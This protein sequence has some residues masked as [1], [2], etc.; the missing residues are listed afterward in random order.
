MDGLQIWAHSYCRS[1]L[2]FYDELSK[3]LDVPLRICL[4]KVDQGVRQGLGWSEHEFDHLD[5]IEIGDDEERAAEELKKYQ[6]WHQLFGVY[7]IFPAIQKTMLL[8]K[9]LG[10]KIGVCSE[11]PLNMYAPG[12]KSLA[13]DIYLDHIL[14][15]RVSRYVSASS[16]ICNFSG[17]STAAL[18]RL[19]WKSGQIIPAG[20]YSP[21]LDGASF[22]AR[23]RGHHQDFHILCS[24]K[25]TWHRGQDVMVEALALL[26]EWRLPFR[27]TITQGGPLLESIRS[28]IDGAKL[29]VSLPGM[30]PMAELI[31]LYESCSLYVGAGRKEPWGLRVNDAL[32]CGA[33]LAVSKG[34]GVQKIVNDYQCG[35]TFENGDPVDLAWK[36]RELITDQNKY[37]ELSGNVEAASKACL[38]SAA[39]ARVVSIIGQYHRDWLAI[40]EGAK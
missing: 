31:R 9:Q 23:E 38:P 15:K 10:C 33:P 12:L 36:L 28:R 16:F 29:P 25:L 39:A 18:R 30:L 8:A 20:Y 5:I 40:E 2:A 1:V 17:D 11:A 21:P 13:K 27:A 19:G 35:V 37:L 26:K 6:S 32:H 34:M 14:P 22:C 4:A 24:G 7:Q 3:C